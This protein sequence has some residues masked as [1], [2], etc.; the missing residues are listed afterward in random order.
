MEGFSMLAKA[1][2]ADGEAKGLFS[3]L[4]RIIPM[5]FRAIG[6]WC[7]GAIVL[8]LTVSITWE[9][10]ARY[11]LNAP[12]SWAI[13]L[14]QHL[15]ALLTFLGGAFVMVIGGHVRA[16]AFYRKFAGRTKAV[17]DTVIY[18]ICIAYLG[19]LT[20]QSSIYSWHLLITWGKSEMFPLFPA[21]CAVTFGA[22]LT[23]VECL[24]QMV[25]SIMALKED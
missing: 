25:H 12:T 21:Q 8:A 15:M 20:W 4:D 17:V 5:A 3:T 16:D 18:A 23:G 24:R 14:T 11:T 6:I 7:G 9:V 22:F 10:F 1:S 19:I 13:D 2:V